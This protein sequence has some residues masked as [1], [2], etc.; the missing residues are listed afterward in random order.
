MQLTYL[1]QD[2]NQKAYLKE[3][4]KPLLMDYVELELKEKVSIL[5]IC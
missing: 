3:N 2:A 4:G 1:L 5:L